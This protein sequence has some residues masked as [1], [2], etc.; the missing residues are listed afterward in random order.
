MRLI[1]DQVRINSPSGTAWAG[2][3]Q[4]A[5]SSWSRA[6]ACQQTVAS[7]L[8][9][10]FDTIQQCDGSGTRSCSGLFAAVS[11]EAIGLSDTAA[12]EPI[13]A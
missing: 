3:A 11:I 4:T 10:P 12:L 13:Q 6:I 7:Q 1:V 2:G 8:A 5:R 9:S